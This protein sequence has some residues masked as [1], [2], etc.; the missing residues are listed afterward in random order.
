MSFSKLV[1]ID[2]DLSLARRDYARKQPAQRRM[3]AQ[4]E[5]DSTMAQD[6]FSS[7]LHRA[8]ESDLTEPRFDSGVLALAIDPL[9][10]PALLTVGSIEYQYG[11]VDAAMELFMTLTSL[12]QDEPDLV[13]IIDKAG[14]FLLNQGDP[15][16]ALRLYRGAVE[17]K[18]GVA[19]YWSGVGYCLGKL[20]AKDEAVTAARKAADLD[21]KNPVLLSDLGWALVEAGC[22][23]EARSV[24]QDAIA[25]APPDFELPRRNLT[26]LEKRARR[27]PDAKKEPPCV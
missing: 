2:P 11:R 17:T 19:A 21:A 5:Y 26:E 1:R 23:N 6:L 9:F 18:P 15:D 10:A 14:D 22:Y 20:G 3:A 16:N 12:S 13:E 24:L 25:A 8:G 7:A 27:R 4:W